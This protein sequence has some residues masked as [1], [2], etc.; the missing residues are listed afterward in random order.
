M[1]IKRLNVNWD[2]Q[3]PMRAAVQLVRV[4]RRF[5]SR[6]LLRF[7]AEVADARSVLSV[8]ILA[9]SLT[10]GLSSSVDVEA[11]GDD[12]QEALQAVT[13]QLDG[14]TKVG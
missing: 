7:G 10:S 6:V 12:E 5:R 4:A 14:G 11:S 2:K 9:S 3:F 8:I 13:E 1:K